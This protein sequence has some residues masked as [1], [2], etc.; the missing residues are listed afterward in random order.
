MVCSQIKE[1]GLADLSRSG[2]STV[3]YRRALQGRRLQVINIWQEK[4]MVNIFCTHCQHLHTNQ[5]G[6]LCRFS[7]RLVSLAWLCPCQQYTVTPNVTYSGLSLLPA[8]NHG[9]SELMSLT[10]VLH[11]EA[12]HSSSPHPP[13]LKFFPFLCHYPLRHERVDIAVSFR[14]EHSTVVLSA[15]TIWESSC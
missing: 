7:L 2:R 1:T 6:Q 11:L 3:Q 14:D 15:L 5:K 4:A 10:P 13:S 9:Y 8:G 12:F